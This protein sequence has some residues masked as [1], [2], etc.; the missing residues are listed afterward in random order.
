[1]PTVNPFI[2]P[3]DNTAYSLLAQA[4]GI[5]L[6]TDYIEVNSYEMGHDLMDLDQTRVSSFVFRCGALGGRCV[7]IGR[8]APSRAARFLA[9]REVKTATLVAHWATW[10]ML[11]VIFA[12]L[13]TTFLQL[14]AVMA[15]YI[16]TSIV[17]FEAIAAL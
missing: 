11:F 3:V 8:S 4:L 14:F 1:M 2:T 12:S 6:P 17:L 9:R 13:T 10:S 15:V 16:Y 5:E 7:Q